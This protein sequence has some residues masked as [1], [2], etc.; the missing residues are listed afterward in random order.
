MLLQID[1]S[2]CD[3]GCQNKLYAMR[4]ARLAQGK[5]MERIERVWLVTDPQEAT[6][7]APLVG[8][9]VVFSFEE[10]PSTGFRWTPELADGLDRSEKELMAAARAWNGK[11]I[12]HRIK[13]TMA[14]MR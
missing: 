6:T 14:V 5:N 10:M 12:K 13:K 7:I 11:R 9:E 1:R 4:Q 2:A 3:A 8:D